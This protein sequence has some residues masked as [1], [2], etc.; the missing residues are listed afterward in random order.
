MNAPWLSLIGLGEDGADAFTPAARALVAQASL[1][2]GGARHLAMI[3]AP[4]ER[5]QWPSPLSDA[6]PQ[7]LAQRGKPT[8][9]LASGDPF[10]YG[11]GDLIAR[12]VAPDE[13]FCI[14]APSAFSLAAARL[15]WSQQDCALL[16]LHGRAFERVTPH[17][18]P[19]AKIIALSWDETTPARL[20]RHLALRGMGGSR[21]HVFERL[22]GP[23]ERVRDA[24]ADAFAL[25]DIAPL[26]TV[27]VEVEAGGDAVVIPLAPGLPDDWFEHD[28]QLTKRDIR[29]V[30]LSALAPRKG[31]LL[32][33]VG[34]GAGSVAI[35]WMLS[36]PANRAIAIER[37][38]ERAA[39]IAR[40]ALSL[41]VPDLRVVNGDAPQA[42]VELE[43]PQAIFIGGGAD[44]ATLA[45]AW[46]ALP[47]LGRIVVNAVTIET[48]SL[49]A[50][51]YRDKGGELIH[52]QIAH[53]RP[54]GRFHALDPA[55][56]VT[57]WRAT[58]R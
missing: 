40:N 38:M 12:H 24:R 54:I 58:K 25:D 51:A 28:G 53:A 13:I 46:D 23:H 10:F 45:A 48:Q 42:L 43:P 16:S 9:V 57:Q 27:A 17:L 1:I 21:V 5:L 31:E 2:V 56:A 20:A 50:N 34:A 15:K 29:A 52:L 18:Q 37:D 4:A 22:G 41:G 14:P 32:W 49:L 44:A 8:V 33:D 39:R 55:M 19:R 7:I 6:L 47:L 36:D 26:N 35:E 3:D 30:T 11:V